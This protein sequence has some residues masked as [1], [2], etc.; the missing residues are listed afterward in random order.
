[1]KKVSFDFDGTLSRVDVQDYAKSL[2]ER[3]IEVWIVTSRLH[4]KNADNLQWNDDL[5]EVAEK[6]GIP[7]SQIHFMNYNIFMD[8]KSY[9]LKE[10]EFIWHLDDDF[11]E[12]KSI[13]R[14]CK[15]TKGISVFGNSTWKR[16]CDKL[17][18]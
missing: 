17:L 14:E 9:W 6:L 13:Q 15:N 1:M 3:G 10:H 4:E 11:T 2:I 18:K 8:D 5:Y 12:I 7:K 16:K